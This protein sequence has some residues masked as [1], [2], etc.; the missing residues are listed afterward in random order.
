MANRGPGR[1]RKNPIATITPAAASSVSGTTPAGWSS[2]YTAQ[3][4]MDRLQQLDVFVGAL[5]RDI[6]S[7]RTE[8]RQ[9]V[10]NL[11]R[12]SRGTSRSTQRRQT[13]QSAAPEVVNG[14]VYQ[15]E[16]GIN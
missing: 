11:N 3:Y 1:P 14:R 2:E 16:T 6:T 7:L 8:C 5:H 9:M 4:L 13:I 12:Q 15:Q 10:S